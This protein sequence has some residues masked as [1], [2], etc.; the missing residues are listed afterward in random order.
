MTKHSG[1]EEGTGAKNNN[2]KRNYNNSNDK[3][4]LYLLMPPAQKTPPSA[5]TL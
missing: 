1:V 4:G 2:W 5:K 3:C